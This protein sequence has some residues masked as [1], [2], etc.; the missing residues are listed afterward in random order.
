MTSENGKWRLLGAFM[1]GFKLFSEP[2]K[3]PFSQ[4][5]CAPIELKKNTYVFTLNGPLFFDH[6]TYSLARE[7]KKFDTN[8]DKKLMTIFPRKDKQKHRLQICAGCGVDKRETD[9]KK[10]LEKCWAGKAR[11]TQGR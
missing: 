8:P 3:H 1:T 2:T 5:R 4:K 6:E 11:N 9:L 10:H 7:F